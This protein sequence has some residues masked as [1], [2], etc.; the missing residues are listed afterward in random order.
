MVVEV[1][2]L[3]L[4]QYVLDRVQEESSAKVLKDKTYCYIWV[5]Y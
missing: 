3:C 1:V 4:G 2:G 5:E